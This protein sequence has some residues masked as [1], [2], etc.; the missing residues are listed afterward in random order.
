GET[1]IDAAKRELFEET[2]IEISSKIQL[3]SFGTLYMCKPQIQYAYHLFGINLDQM[4]DITLSAREHLSHRWAARN[5]LDTLPLM[6]G[7]LEALNY[8]YRLCKA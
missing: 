8:Y 5:E 4:P 7:A 1:A 6:Q 2:G 3:N